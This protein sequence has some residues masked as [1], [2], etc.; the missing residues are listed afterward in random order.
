MLGMFL[1]R[2]GSGVFFKFA[3]ED[4]RIPCFEG[5]RKIMLAS[6]YISQAFSCSGFVPSVIAIGPQTGLQFGFYS[7]FNQLLGR[8][9]IAAMSTIPSC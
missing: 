4:D 5:G 6:K 1:K 8:F 3:R 7:L 9:H 2:S